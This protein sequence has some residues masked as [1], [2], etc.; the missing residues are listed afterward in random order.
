MPELGLGC[1]ALGNMGREGVRLVH[2]AL[3]LGVR[4]FD[5]ADAYGSGQSEI[6]LGRALRGRRH[7]AFIC[8]KGGYLFSERS[9]LLS[10]A[11]PLA[12]T[13]T[14]SRTKAFLRRRTAAPS[15]YSYQ[16]FTPL[17]L[18]TAL[19]ASL[20]RLGTD[21]VDLY[22]LH[23]PRAVHEDVLGLMV[24][25]REE[26][27]IREFGVAIRDLVAARQWIE[28]GSLDRILL[29]FGALDPEAGDQAI[30]A[31]KA[32]DVSVMVRGVYAGGS[33]ARTGKESESGLRPG[34][35]ELLS[36]LVALAKSAAVT[37]SQLAMWFVTARAEVAGV[38]IGT[39]SAH[40]LADAVRYMATAPEQD[41]MRR[42]MELVTSC[43][44]RSGQPVEAERCD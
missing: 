44:G 1:V 30:P 28:T 3:D 2:S 39:T 37:P 10:G 35:P 14:V 31:A 33:V 40:H 36:G 42:M 4:L 11:I 7:E 17:H 5:T 34:Q 20:R 32:R 23:D 16:D 9:A 12:G 27:K 8:T 38:L 13:R 19:E 6:V 41:V 22:Q 29:P 26:G 15:P 24:E 25:L 21:V 18:R 43:C